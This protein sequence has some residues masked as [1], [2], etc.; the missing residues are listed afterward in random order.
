[1]FIKSLCEDPTIVTN[2]VNIYTN[3]K[4]LIGHYIIHEAITP[5][6]ISTIKIIK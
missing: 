2:N 5:S 1:M 4:K 6:K 3:G